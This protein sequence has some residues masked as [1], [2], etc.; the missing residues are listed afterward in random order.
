MPPPSVRRAR[1]EAVRDAMTDGWPAGRICSVLAEKFDAGVRT[2][3]LDMRWVE[4]QWRAEQG[5]RAELRRMR[6]IQALERI[7]RKAEALGDWA[8][9]RGA[10]RDVAHLLGM[11]PT[12]KP[13]AAGVQIVIGTDALRELAALQGTPSGRDAIAADVR[14]AL[15]GHA[16]RPD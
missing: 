13:P 10:R 12:E 9:A 4:R 8:Q 6:Q 2:I 7:A 5:P 15:N 1:R 11:E 3:R 14:A 16:V